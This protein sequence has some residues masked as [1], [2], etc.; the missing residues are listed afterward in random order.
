MSRPRLNRSTL[1]GLPPTARPPD[2]VLSAGVGI[3]HLGLGAFHRSHQAVFTER[4]IIARPG[5]WAIAAAA[6]RRCDTADALAGQDHLY[7]LLERDAERDRAR[8]HAAIRDSL[9]AGRDPERWR[10]L[11]AAPTTR[12]VTLT[13][14]EAG[15][16]HDTATREL[17]RSDPAVAADLAG[18]NPAGSALGLLAA[19][20]A[21]RY[22]AGGGPLAVVSCDNLAGNGSLLGGLLRE[23]FE[24]SGPAGL[25]AWLAESVSFPSSVVDRITPAT[26][27]ADR[28]KVGALLG[29]DDE[30]ATVAE[31]YAQ[32]VLEDTFPGGRPAWPE[33]GAELVAD[34]GPWERAKLRM[35]NAAHC[36]IA[37]L[38]L[39]S[40]YATVADATRDPVLARATE[41]LMAEAAIP[42]S[43]D[44]GPDLQ[45]YARSVLERFANPR[46]SYRLDQVASGGRAKI[47]QRLV[48]TLRAL[49][50]RG[51]TPV[52]SA[53]TVAAW[54]LHDD[55]TLASVAPDLV[56]T[57]VAGAVESW[58]RELRRHKPLAAVS[59][60]LGR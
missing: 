26:T 12:V 57:D 18:R 16:P 2:I 9:C 3:A 34:V 31:P 21:A 59:A 1:A 47:A 37:Y 11:V 44:Q 56:E 55:E 20:L 33:A 29:V 35:L 46:L 41:A 15:Y 32:W 40:G 25:G 7:S 10:Q 5:D 6:P 23:W 43:D 13:V 8:V 53:L 24:A 19:G 50:E 39:P 48:P 36:L 60:V 27:P 52:W 51:L 38:G 22:R 28:D 45:H 58:R 42:L 14:T 49:H 17:D 4:A 54:S 30:V